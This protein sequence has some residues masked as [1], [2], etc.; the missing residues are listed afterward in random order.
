MKDRFSGDRGTAILVEA[1]E[2]QRLL[3]GIPEAGHALSSLGQLVEISKDT[4]LIEQDGRDN[5]VYFIISGSFGV[6]VNSKRV[7]TRQAG[8]AAGEM[9]AVSVTQRRSADV[10]SDEHSLV[11]KVS[12][13]SFCQIA[14]RYPKIWRRL[15]QELSKR[16]LQRNSL[17]RPPH[18]KVRVFVI[19]SAEALHV[20]RAV[21]NAFAHDPFLT[22]VWANGV[23]RVTNYTLETL[24]QELE[25]SDFA[26]AIAHPDDQTVVREESWPSPRDNVVFELGFFMGKLG[27]E[28]AILMEPRGLTVKLPS[29][30]A[31]ITTIKY[32]YGSTEDL[33]PLI[34]PACNELRDHIRMLGRNV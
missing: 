29:D 11:F 16:L 2:S 14:D 4:K 22:V 31:G 12:E 8:D 17:I 5:D 1:L 6:F 18:E 32:R 34:S 28:R 19:S 9:A 26:I 21:E 13:E 15:A 24:E 33:A 30:L 20:A 3:S 25:K 7:A 23:F 10:V 27:M